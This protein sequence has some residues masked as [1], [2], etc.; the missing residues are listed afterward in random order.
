MTCMENTIFYLYFANGSL[1]FVRQHVMNT[2]WDNRV[3]KFNGIMPD[4]I[5]NFLIRSLKRS[6]CTLAFERSLLFRFSSSVSAGLPFKNGGISNIAPFSPHKSWIVNPRS[7]R[8]RSPGTKLNLICTYQNSNED[9]Y[10][11]LIALS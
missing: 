9:A 6:T 3:T 5:L 1:K 10:L 7:P 2:I 4:S 11:S 8:T